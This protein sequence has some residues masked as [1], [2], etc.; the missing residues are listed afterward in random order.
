MTNDTT[1]REQ[2]RALILA[3]LMVLSVVAMSAA[4]A[5]GA[6]AQ[7]GQDTLEGATVETG[8]PD[9]RTVQAGSGSA[10]HEH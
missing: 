10:S 1:Y 3:A 4:F 7:S 6:A 8:S 9:A 2:G 5:G